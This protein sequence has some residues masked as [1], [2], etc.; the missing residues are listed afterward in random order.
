MSKKYPHYLIGLLSL[1]FLAWF[2][3]YSSHPFP[4][5]IDTFN[6]LTVTN[7]SIYYGQ[8]KYLSHPLSAWGLYPF[9]MVVGPTVFLGSGILLTRIDGLNL[10]LWFNFAMATVATLSMFSLLLKI[11]KDFRFVMTG[12]FVFIFTPRIMR[13]F[14]FTFGAREIFLFLTPIFMLLTIMSLQNRSEKKYLFLMLLFFFTLSIIHLNFLFLTPF[15]YAIGITILSEDMKYHKNVRKIKK[16]K[17]NRLI[18]SQL[19]KTIFWIAIIAAIFF[20]IFIISELVPTQ[21]INLELIREKGVLDGE[22][23]LIILTNIGISVLGGSSF[24]VLMFGIIGFLSVFHKKRKN[25]IESL[26]II[27]AIASI[28]LTIVSIYSRPFVVLYTSIF[29]AYGFVWVT[30]QKI[31]LKKIVV[32]TLVLILIIGSFIFINITEPKGYGKRAVGQNSLSLEGRRVDYYVGYDTYNAGVYL[33]SSMSIKER[34]SSY[35]QPYIATR[36]GAISSRP[37]YSIWYS[38]DEMADFFDNGE[39]YVIKRF[40]YE[41]TNPYSSIPPENVLYP[42]FFTGNL[43]NMEEL[44]YERNITIIHTYPDEPLRDMNIFILHNNRYKIFENEENVFWRF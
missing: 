26:F 23:N 19:S 24:G 31:P 10:F 17:F 44:A 40:D 13:F 36:I 35:K 34:Y 41:L 42:E 43:N 33:R 7:T 21:K 1:I 29:A 30:K 18:N 16:V 27:A 14:L 3:M 37:R 15:I 8:L 11:K 32:F 5:G 2:Y 28:P 12:T 20:S 39:W 38:I 9:S 25:S 6:Y 22:S 4:G